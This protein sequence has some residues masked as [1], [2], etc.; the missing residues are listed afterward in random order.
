MKIIGSSEMAIAPTTIFVLKRAPSCSRL[1]S[2]HKRKT[3]RPRIRPK[4]S[5]AAVIKLETAYN[6]AN[7]RQLFGSKGT[8]SDPN[9]KTAARSRVNRVPPMARVQRCLESRRLMLG[10]PSFQQ[11]TFSTKSVFSCKQRLEQTAHRTTRIAML[12]HGIPAS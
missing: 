8:S 6:G 7:E 5:R 1:V 4:T 11:K 9:V 3:V 10:I 12:A 2:A